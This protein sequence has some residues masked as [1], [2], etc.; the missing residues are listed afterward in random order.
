M[1]VRISTIA[2][3]ASCTVL[4]L[5]PSAG[6]A[7]A[8]ADDRGGPAGAAAL[9]SI[10]EVVERVSPSVV[11]IRV[12]QRRVAPRLPFPF[13]GLGPREHLVQGGGSGVIIRG[14]GY[15]LTNRHVVEG[16]S[17]V[18]VQLADGRRF[19]ARV[20]GV[21]DATDLAV[22]HIRA[23]NL[24]AAR[25]ARSED[26]RVGD[27]VIAIGSPF[28][29]E[30]TV[31]AGV[32]SALGRAGVGA[33]E[34]EDYVQTDASINPGN[35]G[36]PLVNLRGEVVGI[37]TMIFGHASGIGFAIP[38]DIARR[39]SEQLIQHG[40]VRRAWIGVS[41]QELTPELAAHFHADGRRGALINDVRPNSPA[42]RAGLRAGDVVVAVDGRALESSHDLL[43]SILQRPIGSEVSLT[44]LRRGRE[45]TLRLTT[46]ER[47]SAGSSSASPAQPASAPPAPPNLGL[48]LGTDE[49]GHVV[50]TR[51]EPGSPASRAGLTPGD[52][53]IT[54]DRR[55]VRTPG[56]VEAALADGT[57]LLWVARGD[58]RAFVV[59]SRDR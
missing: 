30:R 58:A 37:N 17:H 6:A 43:R 56:D 54:A 16:A 28:G 14:D 50:A 32:V 55:R 48:E 46:A 26:V 33:S 52:R 40:R 39:A 41:F 42:A 57:A 49:R 15:I 20:V 4:A 1:R 3:A 13:P 59:L 35:S 5:A 45:Q 51:V 9:P 21:D 44:V 8:A 24:P 27:W 19:T 18:T 53:I 34:I 10:A 38:A 31:T 47:P 25:F 23:T 36:G 29:L 12:E 2:L 22:L 7:P 11:S